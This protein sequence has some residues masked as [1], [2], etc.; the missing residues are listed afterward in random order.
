MA[1]TLIAFPNV[2]KLNTT[3]YSQKQFRSFGKSYGT[4]RTTIRQFIIF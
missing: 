4:Y 1:Y 2:E 3:F